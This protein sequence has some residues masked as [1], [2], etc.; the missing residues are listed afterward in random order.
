MSHQMVSHSFMIVIMIEVC[1]LYQ[2]NI[3]DI[4]KYYYVKL[5]CKDL[6]FRYMRNQMSGCLNAASF[7]ADYIT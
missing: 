1:R 3:H 6:Y 2:G 7:F 5:E 4:H